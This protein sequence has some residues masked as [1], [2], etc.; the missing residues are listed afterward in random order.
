MWGQVCRSCV[1][2][3]EVFQSPKSVSFLLYGKCI[4]ALPEGQ[5]ETKK[6]CVDKAGGGGHRTFLIDTNFEQEVW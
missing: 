5:N 3:S 6:T 4:L 2:V 1:S